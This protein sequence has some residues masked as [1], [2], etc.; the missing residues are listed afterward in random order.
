LTTNGQPVSTNGSNAIP[1]ILANE[2]GTLIPTIGF[3]VE[4]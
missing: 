2:D 1:L 3:I 4:F